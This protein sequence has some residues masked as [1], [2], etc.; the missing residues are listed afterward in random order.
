MISFNRTILRL[1]RAYSWQ[2]RESERPDYVHL[3]ILEKKG[4]IYLYRDY[5]IEEDYEVEQGRVIT[6]PRIR[7]CILM[8]RGRQ[9]LGIESQPRTS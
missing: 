6:R 4:L 3:R 1:Q 9:L 2:K 5:T 7:A 8:Y